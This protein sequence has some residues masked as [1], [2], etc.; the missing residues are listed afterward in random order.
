MPP[1]LAAA[2]HQT[3]ASPWLAALL[4]LAAVWAALFGLTF[5]EW[6]AMA[7]QWWNIDTYNHVLLV[8]PILAWLVWLR[9]D[10]LAKVTPRA[11]SPG[12]GWIA[13]G[14][15]L[16]LAGRA[17]EVNLFAQ[18]GAVMAF[19]GAVLGLFGLRG[20]LV[21]SFPL[22]YAAF[23]VPFG[24]EII[25]ALQHLTAQIAVALTHLSGVPAVVHGLTI[26]TPGGKFLVAEECSGVKFL[27]AMVALTVLA[28][29]TGFSRWLPRVV[30]VSGAIVVS[31]L[32]NGVRAWGTIFVAQWVGEERAGGF[33]HIVYGWIFFAL[34]IAAVLGAAWRHFDREPRESGLTAAEAGVQP[35]VRFERRG[36]A[37]PAALLAIAMMA[38]AFAALGL[39]V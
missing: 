39:V 23:L 38:I 16:C 10:E 5:P 33:D 30:L 31:I 7:H 27:I 2:P 20:S 1:D 25:P 22:V 36:I 32:A 9:R 3:S 14:L 13:A 15:A 37:P 4:R 29:W 11:W 26:D 34:V 17:S 19:Q 28:A 18:A 21:L 12:L 8:P 6:R 35:I 24:D